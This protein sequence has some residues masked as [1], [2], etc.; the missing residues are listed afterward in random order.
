MGPVAIAGDFAMTLVPIAAVYHIA[1]F[2]PA[3]PGRL[4]RLV[5]VAG[6]PKLLGRISKL[7]SIIARSKTHHSGVATNPSKV[8]ANK[9]T[10]T[11]IDSEI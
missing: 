2:I 7:F 3:V 4:T 10:I 5:Q 9:T 11:K 1:H 8:T 6:N